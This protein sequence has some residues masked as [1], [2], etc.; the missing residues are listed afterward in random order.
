MNEEE[1]RVSNVIDLTAYRNRG[2]LVVDTRRGV[3]SGV[4]T[5]RL[6]R[7]RTTLERINTLM[8]ELRR[9]AQEEQH[10]R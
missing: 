8:S 10:G 4:P 5:T 1:R 3:V 7:I 9:S 6:E 2:K